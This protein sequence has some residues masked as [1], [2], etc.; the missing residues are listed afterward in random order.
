M[1]LPVQI[2]ALA[3]QDIVDRIAYVR[4]QWGDATADKTY[5]DL[6]DKLALL[7]T[8][9]QLGGIVQHLAD[10]GIMD[11]RILVHDN[12]TKILYELDEDNDTI[13]VHMIYSST[14]NFQALLYK[15][16][17]RYL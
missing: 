14:Q 16:I 9:P 5:L 17:I 1:S 7:S 10:I 3:K 8:Q 6:M 11:F 2:L 12:H 4:Q 13:Y 15:R